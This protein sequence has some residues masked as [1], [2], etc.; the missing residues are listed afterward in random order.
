M[1]PRLCNGESKWAPT[2]HLEMDT[3]QPD[4]SWRRPNTLCHIP[5]TTRQTTCAQPCHWS[6][7]RMEASYWSELLEWRLQISQ[8]NSQYHT[9]ISSGDLPQGAEHLPY[10]G[11]VVSLVCVLQSCHNYPLLINSER[12]LTRIDGE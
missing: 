4:G 11:R 3:L 1:A 6:V 9:A 5:A 8:N 10:P 12:C 7:V 2:T